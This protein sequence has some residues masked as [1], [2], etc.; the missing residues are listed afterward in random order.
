M[1]KIKNDKILFVLFIL[2]VGFFG[3]ALGISLNT[4]PGV[5]YIFVIISMILIGYL[6]FH[7]VK[8]EE[9]Q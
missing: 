2:A 4:P 3:F 5:S 1:Q 6:L 7:I 8:T 9:T